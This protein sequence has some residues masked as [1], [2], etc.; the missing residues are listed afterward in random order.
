MTEDPVHDAMLGME[1]SLVMVDSARH[2]LGYL[3]D[4]LT[5]HGSGEV[6][7]CIMRTLDL[8]AEQAGK[9]FGIIRKVVYVAKQ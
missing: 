7:A 5:Q 8:A 4:D 3:L 9:S 2:A 6:V 1:D